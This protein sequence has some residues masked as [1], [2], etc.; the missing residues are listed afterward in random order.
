MS[1]FQFLFLTESSRSN[2]RHSTVCSLPKG[3]QSVE[4]CTEEES[5]AS[6][7]VDTKVC[8]RLLPWKIAERQK[9]ILFCLFKKMLLLIAFVKAGT[10]WGS[11]GFCTSRVTQPTGQASCKPE[12]I[13]KGSLGIRRRSEIIEVALDDW[14]IELKRKTNS[15][16]KH[17]F[18]VTDG[19]IA[20]SGND[21]EL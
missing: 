18:T 20:C 11:G 12:Q 17:Q 13:F 6:C 14:D 16:N 21:H 2:I 9:M 8:Q 3:A 10:W 19:C 15:I 4:P 5:L 7:S 1:S